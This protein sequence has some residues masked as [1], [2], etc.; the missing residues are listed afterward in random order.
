MVNR[1]LTPHFALRPDDHVEVGILGGDMV[2]RRAGRLARR[3]GES[4][5]G[6]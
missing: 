2:V 4:Q 3:C 6:G 5:S 1:E